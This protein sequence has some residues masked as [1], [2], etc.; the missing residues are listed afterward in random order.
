MRLNRLFYLLFSTVITCSGITAQ[1]F[2]PV[3]INKQWGLINTSGELVQPA[4]YDAIGEFK[5][6]G[7][8]VMQKNG[9]VGLL[10][11]NGRESLRAQ[12]DDI[13]VLDDRLVAVMQD[14]EWRV[15]NHR[16]QT[17]LNKGYQR[18]QILQ[19]G[20]LRYLLNGK[21]G[22]ITDRGEQLLAPEYDKIEVQN[23][24]Y[25]LTQR[26]D[27]V[28]LVNTLGT[29]LVKNIAA[30]IKITEAG[31]IFYRKG[32]LWGAVNEAGIEEVPAVYDSY[33][34]MSDDY[35]KLF[36]GDKKHF[37][38]RN[39]ATLVR[40]STFT[41]FYAFSSEYLVAK[42]QQRLGLLNTCGRVVLPALYQEIQPYGKG[43][44]RVNFGGSWGV[45][46]DQN[47]TI[48]PLAYQYISPMQEQVC[49]VKQQQAYGVLN[50][51]GDTLV[52]IEFDRIE[53]SP[54]E[55]KAYRKNEAGQ[56]NLSFFSFSPEGELID[57]NQF[58]QHFKITITGTDTPLENPKSEATADYQ[59]KTFEWFYEPANDRWGLRH[60]FSGEVQIEPTFDYIKVDKTLGYTLVGIWKSNDYEFERSS[61][62]FDMIFG[63]V[64]NDLGI[65]VTE[66]N[67]LDVRLEDFR[68]GYPSAR[69][70]FSNGKHGLIDNIGRIT[71]TDLTY[72]GEFSDGLARVSFTGRL[73]GNRK[74]THSLGRLSDY[75]NSILSPS[76]MLDYTQYDQLFQQNAALTCEDCEWGYIDTLGQV[77]I[78]PTY[79]FVQDM[80]NGAGLVNCADKWG[81]VNTSGTELIA[82]RYD[83]IE[84]L[85]NT[86]NRMVRVY[87]QQPKYGLIDTLGQLTV[88]AIYEEIGSFSDGRLAVKKKGLWG[89]VD[90]NGLEVIP[91]RFQEVQDFSEGKAAARIGN[92]W[93]FIDIDGDTMIPFSYDEVGNFRNGLAWVKKEKAVGF[94][95]E[96]EY[97]SIA[98]TFNRAFDFQQNVARVIVDQKYG[99]I[100]K[101]GRY[102]V[103]PRFAEISA[104]NEHGLAI[105]KHGKDQANYGLLNQQG[106]IVTNTD[107]KMIHPFREGLARVKTRQ[108][109]GFIDTTGKIVISPEYSKTGD[110][111]EGRAM[112]QQ[113][114]KCGFIDQNGKLI[115]PCAYS[116][117]QDF[118]GGRAVVYQ[119]IKNAGIIGLD[120]Q[121]IVAP[122]LDRLLEFQEGRGLMRD[123]QYR[124]YYITEQTNLYDGYYEEA[125]AF[126]HGVAVVQID[127]KWGIINQKGIEIIPPKYDHIDSFE[128]GYAR[129][130]IEG[131][132]GLSNLQG[133]LIVEPDYEFISYAGEGLFRVEQGDKIGYFDSKGAW[134]WE[135]NR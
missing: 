56:E 134:V 106:Q 39:C 70:I 6:Y 109:Y 13:K 83:K 123:D 127:G 67:F 125:S 47:R 19:P 135:L 110:F 92:T 129:V 55:A 15:V 44:F 54:Q 7:Y 35:I 43:M 81:M 122:S 2:F 94:I 96:A 22:L 21:W 52:P 42:Q 131:Y 17:V 38:S 23:D 27:Q 25:F 40:P 121:L 119:G 75:L 108:G 76:Y 113:N 37:Y 1:Q 74:P 26:G 90:R 41:D 48:I 132:N 124:F 16:G 71:R 65:L 93:G 14:S 30:E 82:C 105:I 69:V 114:N 53:L 130:K 107:F 50:A 57:N 34:V 28:G 84:F 46:D 120:G 11:P 12:Y 103:R 95:D 33:Q 111:H 9:M 3:K 117:C 115:I 86:D 32:R 133:D 63:L 29:V 58:S 97:F 101:D 79:T 85:A 116:R 118:S 10:G 64:L 8:A 91:C 36:A 66:V 5:H 126:R 68:Q 31:L 24:N 45:V 88:S 78:K 72:I 18:V 20:F 102:L 80:L 49:I 59:L 100:D 62:R 51:R 104:F 61:F 73:S 4:V 89:F 60:I 99:L 112:V 128:G 87:L 98:A 77:Q